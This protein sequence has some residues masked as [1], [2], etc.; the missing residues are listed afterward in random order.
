MQYRRERLTW[1]RDSLQFRMTVKVP[2]KTASDQPVSNK[3]TPR[4]LGHLARQS[5]GPLTLVPAPIR[6]VVPLVL[7]TPVAGAGSVFPIQTSLQRTVKAVLVRTV[8]SAQERSPDVSFSHTCHNT[9][10]QLE[11]SHES[12]C[13]SYCKAIITSFT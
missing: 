5:H 9:E 4:L 8:R 2:T 7:E 11:A 13:D 12:G 3:R 10:E 6:P 1:I